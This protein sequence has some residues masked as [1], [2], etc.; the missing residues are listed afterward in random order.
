MSIRGLFK[1]I[2]GGED[3]TGPRTS[4]LTDTA[5]PEGGGGGPGGFFSGTT[6]RFLD[7]VQAKK[8]GLMSDLS[9]KLGSIK[10]PDNL[11]SGL[12]NFGMPSTGGSGAAGNRRGSSDRRRRKAGSDN[13]DAEGNSS[14]ASEYGDDGDKPMYADELPQDSQVQRR[15][16]VESMD[17]LPEGEA[18]QYRSEISQIVNKVLDAK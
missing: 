5:S 2:V 3:E 10:L 16:S 11:P 9:T 12:A 8:N 1:G 17:S 13:E 14:S 18:Q 7:S 15:A 6:T 4:K